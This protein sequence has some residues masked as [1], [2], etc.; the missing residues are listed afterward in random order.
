M[1]Y[2]VR[3][4]NFDH[5]K[6]YI[7]STVIMSVYT[8]DSRIAGQKKWILYTR[9]PP[10]PENV[11]KSQT[12]FRISHLLFNN[13]TAY[14]RIAGQN[15]DVSYPKKIRYFSFL[16][17]NIDQKISRN[18]FFVSKLW[19]KVSSSLNYYLFQSLFLIFDNHKYSIFMQSHIY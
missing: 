18:K 13:I 8:A 14:C 1:A 11:P 6:T 9:Y 12:S 4:V 7:C 3:L 10:G 17:L 19:S 5:Y 16:F 2:L 15:E